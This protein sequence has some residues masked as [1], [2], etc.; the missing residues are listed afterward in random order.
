METWNKK[1]KFVPYLLIL[2]FVVMSAGII[3]AGYFYYS[4]HGKH[5]DTAAD[6]RLAPIGSKNT[7]EPEVERIERL[8]AIT[9]FSVVLLAGILAGIGLVRGRRQ[10]RLYK[11]K[12]ES[13]KEWSATFDT[14]ADMVSIV[15]CDFKLKKVN[16]SFADV[17]G[18]K[19]EELAGK[20]CYELMHDTNEP[21]ADCPCRKTFST[22]EPAQ[23][24]IFHEG[25][26][27]YLDVSTSPILDDNK[28]VTSV[29]HTVKDITEHK[30]AEEERD[31]M[32]IF[33]LGINSLQQSLLKTTP[34]EDRLKKVT[35]DI[36]SYFDADFCR[37][38]LIK[39]GDMCRQG[40][41][42]AE[43]TEGP[44][45]CRYRDKCLHLVSS[46]GHYTHINGKTHRRVPFGCYK[47]G[48]IASDEEQKFLTNDV[49]NDPRI[50]DRQWAK[51]LGL[52]SFA[53]YQLCIE[54]GQPLGVLALFSKRPIQPPENA[55]LEGISNNVAMAIHK[56]SMEK[57]LLE[58]EEKYHGLFATSHD[59]IMT[60]EPPLWKFKSCNPAT[61]K[62]FKV[63]TEE[64]FASLGPWDVSPLQQPDGRASA[65][66]AKEMIEKAI[67]EGSTFFEWTHKRMNGE[68]FP[69]TVLLTRMDQNGKIFVQST[70]RDVT[71]QKQA[72]E[73]I[74]R[75]HRE[76]QQVLDSAVVQILYL[77]TEGHV[78]NC[79]HAVETALKMSASECRGK[80]IHQL[81]PGWDNPD[82]RHQ[83]CLDVIRT[84]RPLLGSLE[85]FR[86]A[87]GEVRW[88]N[89]D[90][91]PWQN[92]D[93]T[94]IGVLL[95]IYDIT[96][97]TR[98]EAAL[99]Q[100]ETVLSSTFA[101][102]PVII[103]LMKDR[104]I[105]KI[106]N[107]T[108]E[109]SGY[110][111]EELIG[112][113]SSILYPDQAEFER[114]GRELYINLRQTGFN[115]IEAMWRRKDGTLIN[116]L[117]SA[118]MLDVNDLNAGIVVSVLDIT[119]RKLAEEKVRQLADYQSAI[120]NN[121]A[122]MVM[123]TTEDGIFT[124]FNPA[125]ERAFGYTAEEC[126][127]KLTPAVIYDKS[128]LIERARIFSAELGITI[129]P[130]FEVFVTK[131]RRNLPN[132]YEWT[133]IRKDGS[134][135]PI[136]LSV[137]ALRDSLG[138]IIG[139]LGIA[140]D[141]TE[142][143]RAEEELKRINESL[144]IATA[145]ECE[146]A[147]QAKKANTAKSEFLAN[148]SH[149]IRTPLN[150][151]MGFT[152]IMLREDASK[153]YNEYLGTIYNSGK[154]LLQLINDILDLSKIESG[155]MTIE[156]TK[157]SLAELIVRVES[158]MQ[159][160]ATNKGLTFA[161][162]ENGRLPANIL[163]DSNRVFQCL[164]NLVNNAIKFTEKGH[165]HLN[166]SMEDHNGKW[167]IRFEV[168][169]TGIGISPEFQKKMFESFTQEDGS[170]ARKYGGTGLG[171]SITKKFAE[172]LGGTITLSS[173]KGKGTVF[174]FVIPANID[175]ANQPTLE[176]NSVIHEAS[177]NKQ[178]SFSGS[179]LVAEDIKSN[180]MLMKA[181][182]EKMGLKITFADNG[183]EAVDKVSSQSFDLVF[184]DIHMPQMDGYEATRTIRNKGF[185]KPIVALTANAMDGD[186]KKCIEAGCDDYMSKPVIYVKLVA[187]LNKF[188]GKTGSP[189]A[190]VPV[191]SNNL[192]T[193]PNDADDNEVIINWAKVVAGGIDE[194]II[195]Q[196]MPTYL[197]N[198]REHMQKLTSAV[199]EA[200]AIDIVSH[201]HAIKGAGRNL[202]VVQLSNVAMQLETMVR[203]GDL[204]KKDELLKSIIFEFGRV[205]KFV[206][207]P[208]WVETAKKS[209][210]SNVASA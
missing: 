186:D 185:K 10:L 2:I 138:N 79:N 30:H 153:Q 58:S 73:Q 145:R 172:L 3:T 136:L 127:G 125:A 140:N 45:V 147:S 123:S 75:Q 128:E 205:E 80:T 69:T 109:I 133:F 130:G 48:R 154:H 39:N 209:S 197:A 66:K 13:A 161:I 143:K 146:L 55:M 19:P 76:L 28:N 108:Y 122:Y 50:H 169:D 57:Q 81:A 93:G 88:V 20:H 137:T 163:T 162:N 119:K 184:M 115:S 126:V 129:A 6:N 112:Q 52:V 164:I 24:E 1:D 113:S 106:N 156:M 38:W 54:G 16:K 207:Q 149:E 144:R 63:E 157:C 82:Q 171:L 179:I 83:Q 107:R 44:N 87:N 86:S 34:L 159:A 152:E 148:M 101:A 131:A 134:R 21:P 121:A 36:V 175:M 118:S 32:L 203:Q 92:T 165:V 26:G 168:E 67:K 192:I 97:Q 31:R 141:I 173:K 158:M 49:Q 74:K 103:A 208:D 94:I 47:I 71:E 120:L 65:D 56:S 193:Q 167:F 139:F 14:T 98:A 96:E 37:I 91:V 29:I 178:L 176:K 200:N 166:V 99:K 53:G 135:F 124:S 15:D 210:A 95:F 100:S 60:I 61:L 102:A 43:A 111:A 62:L 150:S 196:L 90:K 77:D 27:K 72:E 51:E 9:I 190:A 114:V 191:E 151:I 11:E 182:I 23:G 12:Y 160:F 40:C 206:S 105:H 177:T 180:Q 85:S 4:N 104:K 117:L 189:Q 46:S 35:D 188:L 7:N 5:L 42:H 198:N 199:N 110:T 116:V 142:R 201:A 70:A 181:L 170:V 187:M 174:A 132:E 17:F 202:G 84:G 183:V 155:K 8:S 59:A 68:C 194:E 41:I 18:K 22:C 64:Q 89:V 78:V 195:Q 204:S 33:Q 25:L